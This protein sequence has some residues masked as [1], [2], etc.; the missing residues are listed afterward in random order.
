MSSSGF[1]KLNLYCR[2]CGRSE[3]L[4]CW[5]VLMRDVREY[6]YSDIYRRVKSA[7]AYTNLLQFQQFLAHLSN[8]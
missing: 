6:T 1:T 8:S 5:E 3:Y 2:I 7:Q 4:H